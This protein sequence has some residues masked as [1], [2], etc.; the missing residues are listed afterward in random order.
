MKSK[1]KQL[2]VDRLI[3]MFLHAAVIKLCTANRDF[4]FYRAVVKLRNSEST[5]SCCTEY[6]ELSTSLVTVININ[7]FQFQMF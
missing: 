5:H 7:N 6:C 4:Y 1:M 2:S 3:G